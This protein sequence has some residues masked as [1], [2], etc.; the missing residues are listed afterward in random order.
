MPDEEEDAEAVLP[1]AFTWADYIAR[2][3]TD[4]GGWLALADELIHRAGDRIEIVQDPQTVERGLRRLA[5]RDHRPGGQYGRWML[6]FFG[7][8]TP[9]EEWLKWMGQYHTRFADLPCA[10]RLEQLVLWNRPPIAESPLAC[11]LH[12]GI[13]SAQLTRL[14]LAACEH[15]LQHAERLAPKAGAAAACCGCA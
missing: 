8:T 11:W 9:V 10:L 14:D 6:R 12:V 13:A 4:R 5:R 7:F 15:A 3:V 1:V 2:W